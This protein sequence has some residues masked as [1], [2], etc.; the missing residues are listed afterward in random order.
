MQVG[1]GKSA[2]NQSIIRHNGDPGK[3]A[4]DK[5]MDGG[6]IGC[7]WADMKQPHRGWGLEN[8]GSSVEDWIE[9]S[10]DEQSLLFFTQSVATVVKAS[11]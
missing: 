3:W 11:A 1:V 7:I 5:L 4:S 2:V 6:S 8:L 10:D 9:A